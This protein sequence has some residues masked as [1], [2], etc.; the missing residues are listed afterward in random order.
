MRRRVLAAPSPWGR[1]P[2][3]RGGARTSEPQCGDPAAGGTGTEVTLG[4]ERGDSSVMLMAEVTVRVRTAA[5]VDKMSPPPVVV[6]GGGRGMVRGTY[7]G[8]SP[9]LTCGRGRRVRRICRARIIP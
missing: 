4:D 3:P 2:V 6:A 9:R 8:N 1:P 7:E 5:M